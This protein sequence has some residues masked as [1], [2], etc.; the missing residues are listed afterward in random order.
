[1]I[2][3]D[4]LKGIAIALVAAYFFGIGFSLL[5]GFDDPMTKPGS[6]FIVIPIVG[7]LY[8]FWFVIPI[9]AVLGILIPKI[10]RDYSRQASITYGLLLGV[11]IGAVGSLALSAIG[12]TSGFR[13]GYWKDFAVLLLAMSLYSAF[14]TAGYAY[15]CGK[16]GT[17]ILEKE[18]NVNLP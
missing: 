3:K 11:A 13:D 7:L 14:W 10:A 2:I 16:I 12:I 17:M 18:I 6:I 5:F 4:T 8:T 1:M 15:L 9:G